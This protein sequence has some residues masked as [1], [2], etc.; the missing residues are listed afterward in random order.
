MSR[1]KLDTWGK[2]ARDT[3]LLKVAVLCL[4][5]TRTNNC[6]LLHTN[7]TADMG[8]DLEFLM[9]GSEVT[10]IDSKVDRPKVSD[11]VARRAVGGLATGIS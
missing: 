6:P 2:W 3:Q 9:L 1:N 5:M 10:S 4:H 8:R 7:H 11:L